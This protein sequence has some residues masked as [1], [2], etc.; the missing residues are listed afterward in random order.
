MPHFGGRVD[1]D[2]LWIGG[3][4]QQTVIRNDCHRSK[5]VAA[6]ANTSGVGTTTGWTNQANI[7]LS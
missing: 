3:P 4:P 7:Q 5:T 1:V 2:E 6:M